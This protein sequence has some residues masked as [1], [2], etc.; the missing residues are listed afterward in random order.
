MAMYCFPIQCLV[1]L[2]QVSKP[3][4]LFYFCGGENEGVKWEVN[5][6]EERWWNVCREERLPVRLNIL[7]KTIGLIQW[8]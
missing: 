6:A 1:C 7:K 3:T 5:K 2:I 4:S 8:Y